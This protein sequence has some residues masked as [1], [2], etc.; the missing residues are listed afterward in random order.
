MSEQGEQ[1]E[2]PWL[3]EEIEVT[4]TATAFFLALAKCD[5]AGGNGQA[6]IIAAL[7][8]E[9]RGQVPLLAMLAAV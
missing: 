4:E 8:E 7:P 6:A 1:L 5:Q 2:R 3:P 9:L